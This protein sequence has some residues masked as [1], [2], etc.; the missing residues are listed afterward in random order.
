MEIVAEERTSDHPMIIN[1]ELVQG[2]TGLSDPVIN[3]ATGE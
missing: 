3:P 2:S 1:G